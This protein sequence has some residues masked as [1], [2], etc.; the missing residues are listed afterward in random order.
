M[1][2][3]ISGS[4]PTFTTAQDTAQ[5]TSTEQRALGQ[6]SENPL[7]QQ[8]DA[9]FEGLS[10]RR[11]DAAA[12]DNSGNMR[13]LP[14][15]NV[16][17]FACE[18]L[19]IGHKM[20]SIKP[21]VPNVTN[22]SVGTRLF[23]STTGHAAR[24]RDRALEKLRLSKK[25]DTPFDENNGEMVRA[26]QEMRATLDE[27]IIANMLNGNCTNNLSDVRFLMGD[28]SVLEI[29]SNEGVNFKGIHDISHGDAKKFIVSMGVEKNMIDS[30]HSGNVRDAV[31]NIFAKQILNYPTR[32]IIGAA[33]D[34]FKAAFPE[35]ALPVQNI[36]ESAENFK[37]RL[38]D[39]KTTALGGEEWRN[40]NAKYGPD[41]FAFSA[42]LHAAGTTRGLAHYA[43]FLTGG[44][45]DLST[46]A[47]G[48]RAQVY[49]DNGVAY[50]E[51]LKTFDAIIDRF[52]DL[53]QKEHPDA[54]PQAVAALKIDLQKQRQEL[55]TKVNDF[56]SEQ[57]ML[58][59]DSK[60][61]IDNALIFATEIV[62]TV[63][64]ELIGAALTATT[65]GMGALPATAVKQ[66][67]SLVSYPAM[68]GVTTAIHNYQDTK[69]IAKLA[70]LQYQKLKEQ[71]GPNPV[72]LH[73]VHK[74]AQHVQSH[75]E[76]AD[77]ANYQRFI[78]RV[79]APTMADYA[80]KIKVKEREL[81]QTQER[82]SA[83]TA[84]QL[85]LIK[86]KH[87]LEDRA[88]ELRGKLM[89]R[90]ANHDKEYSVGM[91]AILGIT[92]LAQR[93]DITQSE[94]RRLLKSSIESL[95]YVYVA[96]TEAAKCAINAFEK[97]M[98]ER[99]ISLSVDQ[100][101]SFGRDFIRDEMRKNYLIPEVDIV[102]Y[103]YKIGPGPTF[104]LTNSGKIKE[105]YRYRLSNMDV[106]L[107][108]KIDLIKLRSKIENTYKEIN[109][110]NNLPKKLRD[111]EKSFIS[112]REGDARQ[113]LRIKNKIKVLNKSADNYAAEVVK[114]RVGNF[115]DIDWAGKFGEQLA[116][117]T[118]G[119]WEGTKKRLKYNIL[120]TAKNRAA[121][122]AAMIWLYNGGLSQ[123]IP[124]T[125]NLLADALLQGEGLEAG[126]G[127]VGA[128]EMFRTNGSQ[129]RGLAGQSQPSQPGS[130][131]MG[132]LFSPSDNN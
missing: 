55:E 1:S 18:R 67:W 91:A 121:L 43:T 75:F 71:Y 107:R 44:D 118:T 59:P 65:G 47:K 117:G 129:A 94:L 63:G 77:Q 5:P 79:I 125:G 109:S 105:E 14:D 85:H 9:R 23:G 89:A 124:G 11:R 76:T 62:D 131:R 73:E 54:E 57:R 106:L 58:H 102:I 21:N 20:V 104:Y 49:T 51:A 22:R 127:V 32:L 56:L 45:I 90:I 4:T 119:S 8:A 80:V 108:H 82:A 7:R 70:L 26:T 100:I 88:D 61:T 113:A 123:F 40:W 17:A 87:Q 53:A 111:K 46:H 31:K 38:A 68:E 13:N 50:Q 6:S 112:S 126:G 42:M 92:A 28:A 60:A 41:S 69:D 81:M 24:L 122:G 19:D 78:D 103:K 72:P 3:P 132:S 36:E 35:P 95:T 130:T 66:L 97:A 120:T 2:T 98:G 86:Q 27:R 64:K 29:P 99:G 15:I 52:E 116:N 96:P 25:N 33:I 115:E 74:L 110:G 30:A 16:T 93:K 48:K 83:T 128:V 101:F 37:Q 10:K 84:E 39:F 114:Y 34:G 12:S